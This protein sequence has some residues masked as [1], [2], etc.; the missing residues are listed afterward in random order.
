[1]GEGTSTVSKVFP[2]VLNHNLTSVGHTSGNFLLT[3][4]VAAEEGFIDSI[5][6][7]TTPQ[8]SFTNGSSW[9]LNTTYLNLYPSGSS[10]RV[11]FQ[12][13]SGNSPELE[14]NVYWLQP[15]GTPHVNNF[16]VYSYATGN[17]RP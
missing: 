13:I 6:N 8:L 4:T 7:S 17:E 14:N 15:L 12:W 3:D 11:P 2:G 16:D 9:W 1:M 5:T 10:E